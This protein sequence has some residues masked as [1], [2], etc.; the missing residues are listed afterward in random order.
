[1][2]RTKRFQ[3]YE[4]EI[5]VILTLSLTKKMYPEQKVFV[6]GRPEAYSTDFFEK[7]YKPMQESPEL[8]KKYSE[9]YK[10]N[11]VFFDYHDIT[12]WAQTFLSFISQD[13][14]WPLVYRDDSVVIFLRRTPQNLSLI[15]RY[16]H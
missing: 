8:W 13:K 14:N 10:I 11:Y 1:M 3:K 12:P 15:Q 6:D 9:Q 4:R 2:S 16:G 7:I 5:G